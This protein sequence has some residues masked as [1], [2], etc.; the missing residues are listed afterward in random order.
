MK[1]LNEMRENFEFV[2]FIVLLFNLIYSYN[3]NKLKKII[4]L[5]NKI[6]KSLSKKYL[7]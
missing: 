7:I 4:F 6:Y 5:T 2:L 3:V 1:T